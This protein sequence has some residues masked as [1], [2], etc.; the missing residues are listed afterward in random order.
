MGELVQH[1]RRWLKVDRDRSLLRGRVE[2]AEHVAY[3]QKERPEMTKS[4]VTG[5]EVS[6]RG[7]EDIDASRRLG[8]DVRPEGGVKVLE[9]HPAVQPLCLDEVVL[10]GQSRNLSA[11][12]QRC[13]HA[14]RRAC[15]HNS[16]SVHDGA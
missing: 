6:A 3:L 10:E 11:A 1:F 9:V 13:H 2:V 7:T 8:F 5:S 12:N 16:G 14:V 4:L 15:F